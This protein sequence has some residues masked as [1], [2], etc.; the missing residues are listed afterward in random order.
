MRLP[1]HSTSRA[2]GQAT[3]RIRVASPGLILGASLCLISCVHEDKRQEADGS[4]G[5]KA[6]HADESKGK[7]AKARTQKPVQQP[8]APIV[9]QGANGKGVASHDAILNIRNGALM[10]GLDCVRQRGFALVAGHRGGG[11]PMTPENSLS[12]MAFSLSKGVRVLEI[13]VSRT[14]D[15]GL[16]IMHD[17]RVDRTTTGKG[18]VIDLTLDQIR[19]FSLRGRNG[20][21]AMEVVP[22]FDVVLEWGRGRVIFELDRKQP[23][24]WWEILA[25]VRRAKAQNSVIAIS[26]S[27]AEAQEIAR[28]DPDV[29]ISV[30]L[31][32]AD[33]LAQ[34]R[35]FGIAESRII[36]WTGISQPNPAWWRELSA[37]GLESAFGT[38]G[39]PGA[40]LDSLYLADRDPKEFTDLSQKGVQIIVTDEV[41][42]A[43]GA[44]PR[45]LDAVSVCLTN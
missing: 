37:L 32:D 35:A 2:E 19:G 4:R 36:A 27:L 43:I 30:P 21:L 13:D 42:A 24:Q 33:D 17:D 34:L 20:T 9:S 22:T 31:E 15:N 8:A 39:R 41:E 18:R 40:S 28:Q 26:Y 7:S 23:A 44:I 10:A 29:M 16:I 45:S 3:G 11:S 5:S 1:D 14:K 38:L 12:A 25:A 6:H